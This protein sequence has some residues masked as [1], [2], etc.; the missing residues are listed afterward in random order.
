M[1]FDDSFLN[2]RLHHSAAVQCRYRVLKSWITSPLS[3]PCLPTHP[4][5]LS[6]FPS[7]DVMMI[8]LAYDFMKRCVKH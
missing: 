7:S 4:S 2:A 8:A 1:R 3:L 6:K 5:P